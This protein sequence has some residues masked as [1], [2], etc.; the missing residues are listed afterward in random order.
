MATW[1]GGRQVAFEL[2]RREEPVIVRG[3]L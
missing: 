2:R 3:F 1:R